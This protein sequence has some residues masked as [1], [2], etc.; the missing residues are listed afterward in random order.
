MHVCHVVAESIHPRIEA[1]VNR[2]VN[3]IELWML[4]AIDFRH[5][6]STVWVL[7]KISRK[8]KQSEELMKN[9]ASGMVFFVMEFITNIR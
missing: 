6:P 4:M 7:K 8:R 1:F 3:A 5:I 9:L 2:C